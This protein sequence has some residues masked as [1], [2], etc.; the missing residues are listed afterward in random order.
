MK[1]KMKP[2]AKGDLTVMIQG[3]VTHDHGSEPT[4]KYIIEFQSAQDF[5][6]WLPLAIE[7]MQTK[8]PISIDHYHY[9]TFEM[10]PEK[11]T[12]GGTI[13]RKFLRVHTDEKGKALA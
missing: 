9:H 8:Q 12:I 13:I 3:E 1:Y 10:I 11:M 4:T 6:A 7:A 2:L 5:A